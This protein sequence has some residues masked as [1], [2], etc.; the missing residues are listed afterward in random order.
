M[1]HDKF[2]DERFKMKELEM[3]EK[4][5]S[6]SGL[7]VAFSKLQAVKSV[8]FA[9]RNDLFGMKRFRREKL[10]CNLKNF[11]LEAFK[12]LEQDL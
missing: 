9:P 12:N 4:T 1:I 2:R 5:R 10:L 7:E 3:T 11:M 8:F 6:I